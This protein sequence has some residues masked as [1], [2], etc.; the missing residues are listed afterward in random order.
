MA[1][2]G[3]QG[4]VWDAHKDMALAKFGSLICHDPNSNFEHVAPAGFGSR[5]GGQP[6]NQASVALLGG[7]DILRLWKLCRK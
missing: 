4:D 2:L 7:K 1:Y 3:T 5:M 6:A